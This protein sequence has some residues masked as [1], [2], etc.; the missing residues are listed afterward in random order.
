MNTCQQEDIILK[1]KRD[2]M[3][4]AIKTILVITSVFAFVLVCATAEKS[5]VDNFIKTGVYV[6]AA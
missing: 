6:V 2:F 3:K 5:R 4:K 1:Q